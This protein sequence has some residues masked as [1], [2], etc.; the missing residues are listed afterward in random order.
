VTTGHRRD[1]AYDDDEDLAEVPRRRWP[2]VTSILVVLV[3]LIVGGG[4]AAWRV[5]RSQYYVDSDGGKIVIFQGIDQSVAGLHLFSVYQRTG[6]PNSHVQG[7]LLQLPTSSGS[8]AEARKTVLN[9]KRTYA[10]KQAGIAV[11]TW[12]KN[13]PKPSPSPST[14]HKSGKKSSKTSRSRSS[15]SPKTSTSKKP[16]PPKPPV[17]SYCA[18]QGTG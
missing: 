17:P 15:S 8:L 18:A 13:K 1:D 5:T 10:C 4:Y 3:L 16:Y 14:S 9:I 12:E 6:I 2:V 7:S 11:Q